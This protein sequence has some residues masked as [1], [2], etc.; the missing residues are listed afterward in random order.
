M[1]GVRAGLKVGGGRNGFQRR[2]QPRQ[3]HKGRNAREVEGQL[4]VI[5]V[6]VEV[7]VQIWVVESNLA[8]RQPGADQHPK[9]NVR[10]P[11]WRLRGA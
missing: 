5:V 7:R 10:R 2:G 9:E 1:Q 8:S 3:A 4:A 6:M 11:R